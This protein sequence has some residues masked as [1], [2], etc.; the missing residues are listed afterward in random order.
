MKT[1]QLITVLGLFSLMLL[2]NNL[3]AQSRNAKAQRGTMDRKMDKR[4]GTDHYR[5]DRYR[6]QPIGRRHHYRYPRHR[7][8]VRTLPVGYSRFY[9]GGFN[10]YF[11][12]G[13]YYML[14]GDN[15]VVVLP[16]SGFRIAVLPSGYVRVVVGPRIYFYH[17]GVYY[18][19]LSDGGD[20][21]NYEVTKPPLGGI[22]KELPQD[23]EE[24]VIDGKIL[25]DDNGVLYKKIY[26][27]ED[28]VGYEIVYVSKET[29]T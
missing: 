15:Y 18:M 17:S 14:H 21:E 24:V 13:I 10:Y 2:P 20:Q 5:S 23:A 4:I 6:T 27:N 29:T 1:K 3:E 7:R 22:I 8:Y 9:F 25:Y 19:E 12:A 11:H 16:P 26:L 28:E